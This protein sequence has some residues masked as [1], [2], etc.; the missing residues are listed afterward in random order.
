[1]QVLFFLRQHSLSHVKMCQKAAAVHKNLI[2]PFKVRA[3][4]PPADLRFP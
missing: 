4:Y 3:I 2:K 1:M